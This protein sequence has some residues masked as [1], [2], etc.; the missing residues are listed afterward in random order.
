VPLHLE[1]ETGAVLRRH[2]V[3]LPRFDDT[4]EEQSVGGHMVRE[5]FEVAEVGDR[6]GGVEVQ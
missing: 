4:V 1:P 2:E 5:V 3:A 6:A